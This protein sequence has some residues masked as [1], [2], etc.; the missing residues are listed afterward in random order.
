LKNNQEL[1]Q[2]VKQLNLEF[3]QPIDENIFGKIQKEIDREVHNNMNETF[4][5]PPDPII[6][7]SNSFDDFDLME[8]ARQLCLFEFNIFRMIKPHEFLEI[9]L[10]GGAPNIKRLEN[11]ET[12]LSRWVASR[13]VSEKKLEK[14][15]KIIK[16]MIMLTVN[17]FYLHNFNAAGNIVTGLTLNQVTRLNQTWALVKK[18]YPKNFREFIDMQDLFSFQNNFAQYKKTLGE[19]APPTLP[20]FFLVLAEIHNI[21]NTHTETVMVDEKE[22][23]N[24]E[25]WIKFGEIT[26]M[27]ELYK[28]PFNFTRVE[29][30]QTFLNNE[31]FY[32][33][34]EV[35]LSKSI[36]LEKN[37]GTEGSSNRKSVLIRNNEEKKKRRSILERKKTKIKDAKKS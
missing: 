2:K 17:L 14:R 26:Q 29:I 34:D 12:E 25:K 5:T 11:W 8:F 36:E 7:E 33:L 27:L 35:L 6:P 10:E 4:G 37:D 15:G 30:L 19:S 13:I 32:L 16:K 3:V 28:Q 22:C 20:Y 31:I 21:D 24:I 18:K 9:K 1:I 23:I